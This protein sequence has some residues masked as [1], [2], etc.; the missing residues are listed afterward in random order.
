MCWVEIRQSEVQCCNYTGK[1]G[2]KAEKVEVAESLP[3]NH[4]KFEKKRKKK[5][6]KS[7][8]HKYP[9]VL[10]SHCCYNEIATAN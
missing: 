9:I 3:A 1:I 8:V 10:A 6:V 4:T 2:L 5:E 7:P